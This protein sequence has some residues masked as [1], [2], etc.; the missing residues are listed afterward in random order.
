MN[1]NC[2]CASSPNCNTNVDP[3]GN[4]CELSQNT[5]SLVTKLL[6]GS[7]TSQ[8]VQQTGSQQPNT[9]D[10]N[11]QVY[12]Y[13]NV[14][15]ATLDPSATYYIIPNPQPDYTGITGVSG[16]NT[17]ALPSGYFD[18]SVALPF[19]LDITI[20]TKII[21]YVYNQSLDQFIALVGYITDRISCLDL[22]CCVKDK[23]IS[24]INKYI[25]QLLGFDEEGNDAFAAKLSNNTFTGFCG[26][27]TSVIPLTGPIFVAHNLANS[28]GNKDDP[29]CST[30]NYVMEFLKFVQLKLRIAYSGRCCCDGRHAACTDVSYAD[31]CNFVFGRI[32]VIEF[33][34]IRCLDL[35]NFD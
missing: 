27:E 3:C 5:V 23:V 35:Q 2:N 21:G 4:N 22:T 28:D 19:F 16:P 34:D 1:P 20:F 8:L 15:L 12:E 17:D 33:S 9:N 29:E 10:E 18:A 32:C 7:Y 25:D 6:S 14:T 24:D 31:I 26:A 11:A 30:L 13:I